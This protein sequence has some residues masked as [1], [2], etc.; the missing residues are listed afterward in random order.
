MPGGRCRSFVTQKLNPKDIDIVS[1][2]PSYLFRKFEKRLDYYWTDNWEKEGIDAYLVEL[3]MGQHPRFFEY[4]SNLENWR[5]LYTSTKAKDNF[6]GAN[7]GFLIVRI[8]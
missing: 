3:Y 8:K 1:F 7:K 6:V 4:E 5:K 2:I